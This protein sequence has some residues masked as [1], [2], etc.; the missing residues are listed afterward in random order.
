MLFLFWHLCKIS[1]ILD[2]ST[3][4]H[5]WVSMNSPTSSAVILFSQHQVSHMLRRVVVNNVACIKTIKTNVK[6]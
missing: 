2:I 4:Y 6:S 5:A 1:N 3:D